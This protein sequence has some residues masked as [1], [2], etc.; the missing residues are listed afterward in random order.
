MSD[1]SNT[2]SDGP[3]RVDRPERVGPYAV[4]GVI[5]SGGF[6]TVYAAKGPDGGEVALKVMASYLASQD[7][8]RRFEREGTIRIEHPN[9]VRVLDAGAT[10][11][12]ERYI[13]LE[14]LHGEPFTK[15][16]SR[17]PLPP[18]EVVRIGMD[19]CA[20]LSAA[21]EQGVV[22]RDL[23]PGNVFIC[24][25]GSVKVLDFGI[26]RW[27]EPDPS[28]QLTREGSVVG[29]PG[30]LSPEQARGM[31][32]IDA[33]TD[34]W[35]LGVILYQALSG[36]SPFLRD[37]SVATILAVVLEE[38]D[39]LASRAPP[40]PAGLAAV[41]DRC[42]TK[43]PSARWPSAPALAEALGSIDVDASPREAVAPAML[44]M[45]FASD[46]QRVVALLLATDV[47]DVARLAAV[48]EEWGGELIEMVGRRAI[49]VFGGKR[50]E[51][52]ET[53]RAAAA[54]M[55]ARDAAAYIAIASGRAT[56]AGGTVSGDAVRA[57]ERACAARRP[58][59]VVDA[60]AARTLTG[61]DLEELSSGLFEIP[62][63]A[64]PSIAPAQRVDEP[65]LLGRGAEIAQ[66]RAAVAMLVEE[67]RPLVVWISGPPGI[68]KTRLRQEIVG[69][70]REQSGELRVLIGGGESHKQKTSLYFVGAAIRSSAIATD[71]GDARIQLQRF[72]EDALGNSAW[73]ADHATALGRL[74][75]LEET[76]RDFSRTSD[77]QVMAD[78]LRVAVADV[79]GGLAER[80]P[81]AIVIEDAQWADAASLAL[82]ENLLE[83]SADLPILV[84]LAARPELADEHP[85][86]FAGQDVI[87]IQ[88][89]GLV[90]AQVG[91]L[92]ES[93]AGRTLRDEL[94]RAITA[95]TGGNPFF[96]EQI[97]RE[98]VEKRLVDAH[99][100][101]LPIPLTVEASVQSRLDHLPA[102]EKKLLLRAA[103]FGPTFTANGL[104]ALGIEQPESLLGRLGRRG[105]VADRARSRHGAK[106]EHE[107]RSALVADVAYRML[108]PELA[109]DLHRRA[110]GFL[111][112]TP[113]VEVEI[114]AQHH[115][116]GGE[117]ALAGDAYARATLLAAR[118][119]DTDGVLRCA[120]RALELGVIES[121]R[122][123]LH[124]A[125]AEALSFLG[126]REDQSKEIEAALE[127][128]TSPVQRARA[129][130]ERVAICAATGAHERG[131][132]LVPDALEAARA[133][134][135]AN[136]VAH[137]LARKTWVLVHAGRVD[138]ASEAI[139]EAAELGDALNADMRAVV[140]G[141][142]AQIA[143]ARGDLGERLDA[144]QRAVELF[145]EAGD[146]RRAA[147]EESNLADTFNRL[148]MYDRAEL[149]LGVALDLTRRV[150][151]RVAEAFALA[152]LGYALAGQGRTEDALEALDAADRAAG[153]VAARYLSIV[154]RVY[155]ARAL[156]AGGR[157]DEAARAAEAAADDARRNEMPGVAA[158]ALAT[159]AQAR[160]AT[161][162][163][164][165]ALELSRRAMELHDA[166][167]SMEED[168]SDVF[169]AHARALSAS[170]SPD[171]ALAVVERGR[172]RL[173][174]IAAKIGDDELRRRF[175]EDV[176]A[177]RELSRFDEGSGRRP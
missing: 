125:R 151:N 69:Q 59:V 159:A 129:L 133:S 39:P 166:V 171:E 87:R 174:E 138:E 167:G 157:H 17:A 72:C 93:I 84:V 150:G 156:L 8:L 147:Q 126:R 80:G 23:K 95:R 13:A 137:A 73:A 2:L 101:A 21:H 110:A 10:P 140:G 168:E 144:F 176:P 175:L 35:A 49:G 128:A 113:D 62:R 61:Y 163:A 71:R 76:S 19:V 165:L 103:V 6:G 143:S 77:P 48:V 28:S 135:D 30:Y 51:G 83:R 85:D 86:L 55:A 89:R 153:Q 132:R 36:I 114:V 22:H 64:E 94:V 106:G 82:L 57:V 20:G 12:G 1:E 96:V 56:G 75:G 53:S 7:V 119:G 109:R 15:L 14:L 27:L 18:S 123:D 131:L 148:G 149:A 139:E 164:P 31:R 97:V 136:A 92:A 169:L 102:E 9:V 118:R 146:L 177:N 100:D 90:A 78:K 88:P 160:L 152:N 66:L 37:S 29:T 81:L 44:S 63:G 34:I 170:G 158:A 41:V 154:V 38:A 3:Y 134:N 122:F 115:E 172:A 68:G 104:R 105:L 24:D 79:L 91:A 98:T 52:D 121:R 130:N 142:R 120:G 47:H 116:R 43:D 26:A 70:L 111:A 112:S 42:L 127:A 40:L 33:R 74:F 99:L 5:G 11:E 25:D 107:L 32:E 161:G 58:G 60:A 54:A 4:G 46:E 117:D 162:A 65:P 173:E 45:S 16:L 141:W 67:R 108:T 124:L 145:R 155:R 50:S